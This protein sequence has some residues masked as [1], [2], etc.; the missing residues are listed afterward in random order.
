MRR[1]LTPPQRSRN[2][3][4]G[5]R[6]KPPC[7]ARTTAVLRAD[8]RRR[9]E[10]GRAFASARAANRRLPVRDHERVAFHAWRRHTSTSR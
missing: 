7:V 1:A 6:T 5:Q 3:A 8:R 4:P 10:Q 2:H 9:R